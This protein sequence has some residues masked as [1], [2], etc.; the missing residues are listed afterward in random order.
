MEL[1]PTVIWLTT[2]GLGF[3]VQGSPR[4]ICSG[5]KLSSLVNKMDTIFTLLN[6]RARSKNR[7]FDVNSIR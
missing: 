5:P 2:I 1:A 6:M 7:L 4:R 3:A